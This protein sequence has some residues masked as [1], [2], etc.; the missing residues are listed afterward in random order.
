MF[1]LVDDI[2]VLNGELASK[3]YS[4]ARPGI[5]PIGRGEPTATDR[6]LRQPAALL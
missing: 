1:V 4:Y 3:S 5:E 2:D 6:S